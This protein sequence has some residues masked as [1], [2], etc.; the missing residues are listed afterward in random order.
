MDRDAA[1]TV[2]Q[3]GFNRVCQA[4]DVI[5]AL[6]LGFGRGYYQAVNDRFDGMFLVAIDFNWF[7]KVINQ[8]IHPH[9]GEAAL[10]DLVKKRLVGA[11]ALPHHRRQYEQARAYRQVHDRLY[12]LLGGLLLYHTSAHRAVGHARAGKKQAEVVVDL[13]DRADS[14]TRVI[15]CGFL[16]D[17]NSGGK[18]FNRVHIG[19][20][21][22]P[23]ILA[24]IRGE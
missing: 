21:H 2:F 15:G 18:P 14:R 3:G 9:A 8:S 6:V 4:G 5:E 10:A 22:L 1:L 17:R 11:L 23:E 16:I 24:G 19:F 12:D 13:S 20:V 7:I